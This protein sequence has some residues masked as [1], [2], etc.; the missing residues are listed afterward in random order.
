MEDMNDMLTVHT[1]NPRFSP[2]VSNAPER[3]YFPSMK[4]GAED[5]T[6]FIQVSNSR[7]LRFRGS[8]DRICEVQPSTCRLDLLA[9][10]NTMLGRRFVVHQFVVQASA[11][12]R[13]IAAWLVIVAIINAP[14]ML[15]RPCIE[16]EASLTTPWVHENFK[17]RDYTEIHKHIRKVFGLPLE[18]EDPKWKYG[19]DHDSFVS[20]AR[21]VLQ[22]LYPFRYEHEGCAAFGIAFAEVQTGDFV[23][24]TAEALSH[25][26]E[27]GVHMPPVSGLIIRPYHQASPAGPATFRLVSMCFAYCH[28]VEEPELVEVVLV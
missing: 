11:I 22:G 21:R 28:D 12:S 13:D 23:F 7:A 1:K 19:L 3:Y 9:S 17:S 16:V 15:S 20:E 4:L 8:T 26:D 24:R 25:K 10:L 5:T 14:T 18:E 2:D 6:M 27:D